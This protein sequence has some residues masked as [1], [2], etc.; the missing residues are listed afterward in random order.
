MGNLFFK[1][2]NSSEK[3]TEE[4]LSSLIEEIL[5]KNSDVSPEYLIGCIRP[6]YPNVAINYSAFC[7]FV[8]EKYGI[9][10]QRKSR[11]NYFFKLQNTAEEYTEKALIERI[12][13]FLQDSPKS[14]EEI[15]KKLEDTYSCNINHSAVKQLIK[16]NY[17]VVSKLVLPVKR[18]NRDDNKTADIKEAK[19]TGNEFENMLK[20]MEYLSFIGSNVLR[21]NEDLYRQ[22]FNTINQEHYI[23]TD[24]VLLVMSIVK[25]QELL[26][27]DSCIDICI[28]ID[29][30][31]DYYTDILSDSVNRIDKSNSNLSC[32]T[33]INNTFI[34]QLLGTQDIKTVGD[35]INSRIDNLIVSFSPDLLGCIGEI[36][37][38]S[39]SITSFTVDAIQKV[40]N[41][42]FDE[43]TLEILYRRNGFLTGESETLEALGSRY[44]LTRERV[45]QV[46]SKGN[47]R[48]KAFSRSLEQ[49]VKMFFRM[50]INEEGFSY[51][52]LHE[53]CDDVEDPTLVYN[54][55]LLLH[56]MNINYKY[57][58]R[59]SLVYDTD[60]IEI[61]DIEKMVEDKYGKL[62]T[63]KQYN[64]ATDLE[65][66]IIDSIYSI[67]G[68][69]RNMYRL[70]RFNRT[71][72][73]VDLI[74]ELFSQGYGLYSDE[75]YDRL[76][77]E[78]KNRLGEE[79]EI[80]SKPAI[81]GLLGRDIFCLYDRGK[82]MLR[83][84]CGEIPVEILERIIEFIHNHLPMVDYDSIY[85]TFEHELN[86]IG[87]NN[88][89]HMKGLLD[90][91][92]P[93]DLTTR[94]DYITTAENQISSTEARKQYMRSFEGPFTLNDLLKKYPGVKPYVFN[95]LLY[96]EG[97]NGLIQID[98]QKY[99][100]SDHAAITEDQKER[101]KEI[102]ENLFETNKTRILSSRKV[103]AKLRISY[104]DLLQELD[105]VTNQYA[106]FSVIKY[107]LGDEYYFDRPF[108]SK[109]AFDEK[110]ITTKG[111]IVNYVKSY[112][113][114]DYDLYK[115]YCLKMNIP[116]MY[117]FMSLV[118]ELQDEYVQLDGRRII[119]KS[120]LNLS[121]KTVNEI[122]QILEMIFGRT[123]EINTASFTGYALLPQI[124]YQWNKH[125]FAGIVR[126]YLSDICEVENIMKGALSEAIDYKIRRYE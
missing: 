34:L 56:H 22:L 40:F 16:R 120:E 64:S 82:Y 118:D 96:E 110:G 81:R 28:D 102:I 27:L 69:D 86:Y 19:K 100:Y 9:S 2:T 73:L 47:Q 94:R 123:A 44:D 126:S 111:L 62:M 10:K 25:K 115:N 29:N 24:A 20:K 101:L 63:Q 70:K 92:L 45:R 52:T 108:I 112:E 11:I 60:I 66:E 42:A 105:V 1:L 31:I 65:K 113:I 55:C 103:Y 21:N 117:T 30:N 107:A 54:A 116:F 97:K 95:F 85:T 91:L 48:I 38:I 23:I 41:E 13:S 124:K 50:H 67:Y 49:S 6:Y 35:I 109:D 78:Y 90:P 58:H 122:R 114:I 59:Y 57:D 77:S 46:E 104:P 5:E 76:I 4:Y 68:K 98:T 36:D 15:I 71:S 119:R 8:S 51:R 14:V 17:S 61:S 87:I 88:K 89:Y 26:D 18:K 74:A 32:S 75:D 43:R 7:E 93:E 39:E 33:Y 79:V 99:I 12:D 80:P 3:Y 84:E 121:D 83:S 53:I 125:V 106:M 72:Y 37:T